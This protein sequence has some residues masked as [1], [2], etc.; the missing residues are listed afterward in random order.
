[1]FTIG[2]IKSF[3]VASFTPF[4]ERTSE[5]KNKGIK[6]LKRG[7]EREKFFLLVNNLSWSSC[8]MVLKEFFEMA[9]DYRAR[10]DFRESFRQMNLSSASTSHP[11][12]PSS[13]RQKLKLIESA[14]EEHFTAGAK[15]ERLS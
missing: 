13:L 14:S 4:D 1:M 12:H 5:H 3:H 10:D 11:I 6:T 8:G 7:R 9:S 2:N 15:I